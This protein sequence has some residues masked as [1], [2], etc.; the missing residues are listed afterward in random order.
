MSSALPKIQ[1]YWETSPTTLG[2]SPYNYDRPNAALEKQ[3]WR[4]YGAGRP[5]WIAWPAGHPMTERSPLA[6]MWVVTICRTHGIANDQTTTI[7][8]SDDKE[9]ARRAKMLLPDYD[10][11]VMW[12]D[13]EVYKTDTCGNRIGPVY[14]W[15]EDGGGEVE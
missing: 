5:A 1:V 10:G 3:Q 2:I 6:P 15:R 8:A 7:H 13:Y 11:D 14:S 9:A 12:T 4:E